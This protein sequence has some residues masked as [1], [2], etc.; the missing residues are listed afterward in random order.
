MLKRTLTGL[1]IGAYAIVM[2][3]L[4]RIALLVN[5]L[6]VMIIGVYEVLHVLKQGGYKPM[7]W[8]HYATVV[9]LIPAYLLGEQLAGNGI[10]AVLLVLLASVMLCMTYTALRTD[11][12]TNDMLA[13]LLPCIYPTYPLLAFVILVSSTAPHWRMMVWLMLAVSVACDVFALIGGTTWGKAGKHKLLP[14]VS[15]HKTVEGAVSGMIGALLA[16]LTVFTI[17]TLRGEIIPLVHF[18]VLGV[19]GGVATQAGDIV[20]SYIKRFCGVKDYGTIFPGHGGVL[21]RLDGILFNA[22]IFCIYSMLFPL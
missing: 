21:D 22:L 1:V 18:L 3:L 5:L 11:P 12:N 14:R 9:A 19:L 8:M 6:A 20:A 13:S 16:A 7:A 17:C 10:I 2:V 4:G 15:P